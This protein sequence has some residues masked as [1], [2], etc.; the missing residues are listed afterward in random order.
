MRMDGVMVDYLVNLFRTYKYDIPIEYTG[1][2][3]PGWNHDTTKIKSETWNGFLVKRRYEKG[4]H[5]TDDSGRVS[6]CLFNEWRNKIVLHLSKIQR[7]GPDGVQYSDA[8][9]MH[10]TD[11]DA[12]YIINYLLYES[13]V[14][15]RW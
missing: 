13:F 12:M 5:F 7:F 3:V 11:R 2:N 9:S 6:E 1:L 15:V 8:E 14:G 10:Q 4:L